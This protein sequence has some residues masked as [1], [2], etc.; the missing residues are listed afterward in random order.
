MANCLR[1]SKQ[2]VAERQQRGKT[3]TYLTLLRDIWKHFSKPNK[4]NE[5]LW[6]ANHCSH[7]YRPLSL[8]YSLPCAA[9]T[10][11]AF[12]IPSQEQN[13][14]TYK[15]TFF[16]LFVYFI[17][18]ACLH[19]AAWKDDTVAKEEE[20]HPQKQW[21]RGEGSFLK[22]GGLGRMPIYR[23]CAFAIARLNQYESNSAWN[24]ISPCVKQETKS[25]QRED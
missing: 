19:W 24:T 18:L 8:C 15:S 3:R 25:T 22:E 1:I 14:P 23:V 16:C 6:W 7:T 12:Q 10:N 5:S 2:N 17:F 21:Q 4:A 9:L 13:K 11:H 20:I